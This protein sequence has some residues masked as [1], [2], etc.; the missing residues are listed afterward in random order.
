[1]NLGLS[2]SFSFI[3][4][5]N[6]E[7]PAKMYVDYVRVYQRDGVDQG[8]TCDPSHHPTANYIAK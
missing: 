4:F 1:M 7:F 2:S 3:D 6:L 5:A 8:V